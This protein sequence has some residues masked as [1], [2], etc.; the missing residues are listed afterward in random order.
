MPVT[1]T[2]NFKPLGSSGFEAGATS[3]DGPSRFFGE[4]RLVL[5]NSSNVELATGNGY[6]AGGKSL[7]NFR[8]VFNAGVLSVFADN[9][10][11]KASGSGIT[12]AKALLKYSNVSTPVA[13]ID[14]GATLTAVANTSLGVQWHANGIIQYSLL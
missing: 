8:Y 12:A 3:G 13:T 10:V 7:Q 1:L 6:T 11:W 5:T 14:F 9:V 4:L 2:T